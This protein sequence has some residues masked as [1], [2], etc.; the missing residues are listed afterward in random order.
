MATSQAPTPV[1][2]EEDSQSVSPVVRQ[3]AG[4]TRIV[5]R[6]RSRATVASRPSTFES[7]DYSYVVKD[8]RRVSVVTGTLVVALIIL[9]F[10]IH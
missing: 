9:S 7:T 5:I 3:D 6:Q 1:A 4:E 2:N 10:V 8:L